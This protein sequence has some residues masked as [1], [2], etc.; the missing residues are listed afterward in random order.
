MLVQPSVFGAGNK[1]NSMA[2]KTKTEVDCYVPMAPCKPEGVTLTN[3]HLRVTRL[4]ENRKLYEQST[5]DQEIIKGQL[6]DKL[7]KILQSLDE[8]KQCC[9]LLQQDVERIKA[10]PCHLAHDSGMS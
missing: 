10:D 7:A 8:V 2:D 1:R 9:N 5:Q 6:L 3:I 4:E